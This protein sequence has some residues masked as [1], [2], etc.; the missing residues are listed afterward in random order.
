[1]ARA[2]SAAVSQL[3]A[4]GQTAKEAS[5]YMAFALT[6]AK[7][8]ALQLIADGLVKRIDEIGEANRQDMDAAR[9]SGIGEAM[10]DRLLLNPQRLEGMAADVRTVASLPDPVG[11]VFDMRTMPNG[12]LLGRQRVPIGVIGTIYESRPNVTID[13][14]SLCLK[15]GNAVILRGGSEAMHSNAALVAVV[16]GACREAGLPQG[17][18]Q[19]VDNPDRE[20]VGHMLKMR[21]YIDLFIPRGGAGLIR[22]VLEEAAMPVV[23]GG[24]GVCH[25]F[26]D[27]SADLEKA[28]KIVYNAKVQ[29]P[30]VC[31]ALDTVLVHRDAARP[32]LSALAPELAAAGVE[33]HADERAVEVLRPLYRKL[34]PATPEDWGKEFL[35]LVAA[36]KTVASLEEALEHI[37]QH[38]SG[39]SEAIVTEDYSAATR[40]L[41]EVDA[42]CVYVNASTRFTDGGQFGLGTEVGIST[43]KLHARGP[44]GL[45]ELTTYKWIVYGSGQVRPG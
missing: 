44:M 25:T 18:V 17:A 32:F 8:R 4:Q 34:A 5:R 33:L 40:F 41:R 27:S 10:L 19:F 7:N 37:R 12:L 21:Q 42:A 24:I 43:G 6:E 2:A 29:R 9:A 15:S 39:H 38:G 1:M 14:S 35:S 13:I 23:A 20:L 45:R 30:T 22:R 31:N 26:V 36:I 3:E 16:T 11:E 28:V